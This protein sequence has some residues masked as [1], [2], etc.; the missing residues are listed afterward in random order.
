M[1]T[2]N[3]LIIASLTFFSFTEKTQTVINNDFIESKCSIKNTAFEAGENVEFSVYYTVAGANF[4]AGAGSFKTTSEVL[5]G[6]PVY[7]IVGEGKTLPSYE[8]AYKVR[9]TYET[10]IDKTTMQPLKFVRNI[11][12]GGYKKYQNISFNKS[13]NTAISADGTF[14]IPECV[15]D[16]V[17]AVFYA[18]NINYNSLKVGDRIRFDLF[19]DNEIFN[20]YIRYMGKET[21]STK[22]GKVKTI[23]IKPLT[24]KGTI[25]EGGEKMTVWLSDDANKVPVRV[26]SPIIVG[27]VRLDMTNFSGLRSPMTSVI[28]KY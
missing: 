18:R 27:S 9:D 24:I 8:W 4:N 17:S 16:V 10:Y 21:I 3:I 14:K 20:M 13:A 28:K 7:H 22:Y 6:H 11:N 19:L 1:K 5:N 23:K 12:E 26:E 2:F 15:Q 25:F